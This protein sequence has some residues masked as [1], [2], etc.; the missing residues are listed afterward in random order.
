MEWRDLLFYLDTRDDA[1][2]FRFC[3]KSALRYIDRSES[4]SL[5]P[6]SVFDNGECGVDSGMPEKYA[7]NF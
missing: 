5:F 1:A 3:E 6:G 7:L 2:R 4:L